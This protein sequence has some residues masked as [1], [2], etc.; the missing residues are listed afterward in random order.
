MSKQEV[1]KTEIKTSIAESMTAREIIHKEYGESKNFMTPNNRRYGKVHGAPDV[2]YEVSEGTDFNHNKI[3]G[4]SI[5]RVWADGTTERWM[6][7]SGVCRSKAEV[8][9]L[10]GNLAGYIRELKEKAP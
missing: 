1:S 8:D 4:V 6:E 10:L 2:A 7:K 9:T 5:V 3:Y